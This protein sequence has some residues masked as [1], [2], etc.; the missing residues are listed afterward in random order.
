MKEGKMYLTE[1]TIHR[2]EEKAATVSSL[3]LPKTDFRLLPA[4]SGRLPRK[5]RPSEVRERSS[6]SRHDSSYTIADG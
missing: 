5:E 6:S 2:Y 3:T 4:E 1:Q